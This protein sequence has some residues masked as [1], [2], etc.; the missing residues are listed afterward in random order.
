ME[1]RQQSIITSTKDN[2]G[3]HS[4]SAL[5]AQNVTGVKIQKKGSVNFL[6]P[7]FYYKLHV[8]FVFYSRFV[9]NVENHLFEHRFYKSCANMELENMYWI[10]KKH[11]YAYGMG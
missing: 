5:A 7:F 6:L 2:D 1:K 11:S 4:L 8:F 10:S 3:T 9:L